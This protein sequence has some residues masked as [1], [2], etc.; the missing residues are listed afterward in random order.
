MQFIKILHTVRHV[1]NVYKLFT[2]IYR[3]VI[4]ELENQNEVQNMKVVVYRRVSTD[5]Q[6]D[7]KNGLNSQLDICVAWAK[8]NNT[9]IHADFTDTISGAASIEKRNGLMSAL[10]ELDKGSVLLVAKR[11]RLGR[12]PMVLAMIEATVNR[13][14]ASIVS[15]A[16]EGTENDDPTSVLMRRMV[17]AFSEYERLI[18][19]ARTKA[20]LAAK[21]SRKER[22][23]SIP[24]G[25]SLDANGVNLIENEGEMTAKKIA[26]DLRADGLGFTAIARSLADRGILAR[27]GKI[28]QAVQI[29]RMIGG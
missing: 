4:L 20:A 3:Y 18:I 25:Y 5:Q 17:D 10:N 22:T 8:S 23:G 9:T 19:G 13:A 2:I 7:S 27:N 1:K 14:G 21:K 12:D 29:Q 15:A 11:D 6:S 26:A 24:F 16:G 28:F